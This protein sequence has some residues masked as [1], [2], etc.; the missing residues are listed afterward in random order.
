[1]HSRRSDRV[2][3][4][5]A[6]AVA[7]VA[8][9]ATAPL[10][11]AVQGAELVIV[12]SSEMAWAEGPPL[13]PQGARFVILE[14]DPTKAEPLTV[15]FRLPAGY[16]VPPHTHPGIEHVTVLQGVLNI[17]TG[18]SFD[19]ES[20]TEVTSGGFAVIAAG[21][22]HFVW[23]SEETLL[24]VHSIGPLSIAYI[25]PADDPRRTN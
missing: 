5:R 21:T 1:M 23:T 14:G 9:L 15:R 19:R 12:Q 7:V 6:C 25:N 17:G 4:Y 22:P 16:R 8:A 13:L 11:Q 24:Q 10:A 3:P 18:E 2:V 20:A